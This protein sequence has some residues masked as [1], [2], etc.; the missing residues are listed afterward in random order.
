MLHRKEGSITIL[1]IIILLVVWV[2]WKFVCKPIYHHFTKEKTAVEQIEE[3]K[4]P[5]LATLSGKFKHPIKYTKSFF[6]NEEEE[7]EADNKI[8]RCNSLLEK[9][10]F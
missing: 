8:D 2:F 6:N 1:L 7:Q 5:D 4:E 9:K 3:K 10:R